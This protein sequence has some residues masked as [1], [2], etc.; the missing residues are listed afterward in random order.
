MKIEVYELVGKMNMHIK[1]YNAAWSFQD[2][3]EKQA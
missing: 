3:T 1:D 2:S